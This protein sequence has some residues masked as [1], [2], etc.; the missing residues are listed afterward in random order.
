[1]ALA[2]TVRCR[3]LNTWRVH[4]VVE[5]VRALYIGAAR[6]AAMTG[7]LRAWV[8][9]G[10][11]GA[12][13]GQLECV[14]CPPGQYLNSSVSQCEECPPDSTT[15]EQ[16]QTRVDQCLCNAGFF[17]SNTGTCE[18]CAVGTYKEM[19]SDEACLSCVSLRSDT[20]TLDVGSE[21]SDE[22]VCVRG[23]EDSNGQCALCL[24]GT[25]KNYIGNGTC[26]P[27]PAHFFCPE[28]SVDPSACT[29]HSQSVA[30][31]QDF[32]NCRCNAGFT[33]DLDLD[34]PDYAC[35]LCAAG[36]YKAAVGTDVCTN[37]PIDT[38]NGNTGSILPSACTPCG[39][40]AKSQ[41]GST[42][43]SDCACNAGYSGVPSTDDCVVC[44][45]GKY[46]DAN[47]CENCESDTYNDKL[48]MD[49]AG[50]CLNCTGPTS[51]QGAVGQAS[52]D[53]CVCDAGYE[54]SSRTT[55]DPS[56]CSACAAGTY[57]TNANAGACVACGAGKSSNGTQQTS[58]S[59]C[60]NC[61]PGT[62]APA[63][64]SQC[65]ECPNG[66]WQADSGRSACTACPSN[67][68]HASLGVSDV[69]ECK[70]HPGYRFNTGA[71][72]DGILIADATY[73]YATHGCVECAA[74]FFCPTSSPGSYEMCP[75]NTWSDTGYT[76]CTGCATNSY[77]AKAL[78]VSSADCQC[79]RGYEGPS[80]ADCTPC[81]KGSFQA[82]SVTLL[83]PLVL[84]ASRV[85]EWC[86]AGKYSDALGSHQCKNCTGNSDNTP[87][88][89]SIESCLC[90]DGFFRLQPDD[91]TTD[92]ESCLAG[93]YCNDGGS[94][95]CKEN[96]HSER[97]S[98]K[99][100]NCSCNAGYVTTGIKV[101]CSVCDAG[102]YCTGG[103]EQQKCKENSY[104]KPGATQIS[105]CICM[106]GFRRHCT[107]SHSDGCQE[108][109]SQK[110]Y[111]CKPGDIC[112]EGRLSHCPEHSTTPGNS[113]SDGNECVCNTGYKKED[114]DEVTVEI[115][116]D[117]SE[118]HL[119]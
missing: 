40:Y 56:E 37:C 79:N 48:G 115:G 107:S 96:S 8:L 50:E 2:L 57:Q 4:V 17:R 66:K 35:M 73:T 3:V 87:P 14:Q 92:C 82:L 27:C 88:S 94:E 29:D 39:A 108:E 112:A 16:G 59:A 65:E 102:S 70:C 46:A 52:G 86:Q 80:D 63:N 93:Y 110:C 12:A 113:T 84:S 81:D 104:P 30:N 119:F 51:T 118:T 117:F 15:I 44:E 78:M 9:L 74:G 72:V 36:T 47:I 89:S 18:E 101:E 6:G 49:N 71:L 68:G 45:K 34:L 24:P 41:P 62:F 69:T 38:F 22:C 95:Q 97:G 116:G 42:S 58:P 64:S 77:A 26:S 91:Y 33:L 11:L 109:F 67:S 28:G 13:T 10:V 100:A 60:T 85:C 103:Y 90:V 83:G 20:D 61:F 5:I 53:S 31:S 75:V 1:M 43:I 25:F 54:T 98:T 7:A 105:D 55:G 23:Y 19:W 111:A 114:T 76:A 32:T 99:Q 106:D 21:N